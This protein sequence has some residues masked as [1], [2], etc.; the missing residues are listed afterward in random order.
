M[1]I[2]DTA[3][4]GGRRRRIAAVM[5][6][7]LAAV[8]ALTF[9]AL[10]SSDDAEAHGATVFPGSRQYLCYFDAV[11]ANG[12]LDPYNESCQNALDQGGPNAF[13]NWFGNLDSNGA[14][15]TVGYIP[16]G[17]IC[18]GGGRGPYDFEAFNDPGNW[19]RTHVTAGDTVEWR[20]NNWA[21]HPGKFDLYI[22]KD[23]WD[24]NQPIAWD[25]LE[26]FKTFTNPA[27]NGGPGSN[28]HYYYGN[29]TL[30]Q[31][32][33]YHVV[34]T[35]WVRSDSNENFYACSDVEFDGGNG[36]VS[37]IRPGAD[38]PGNDGGVVDP[39]TDPTSDDPTDDPTDEPTTGGP[40][41]GD[42]TATASVN[43]WGSGATV[44]ITV[45]NTGSDPVSDWMIHW[46]WPPDSGITIANSW[47][48]TISSMGDMQMAGPA[49]WNATIASGQ[50]VSFGFNVNGSLSTMPALDCIPG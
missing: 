27:S 21:H 32:S 45:S 48:T 29:L 47:N 30:P 14:G 44:T 37:G 12:A 25:D 6:L 2:T 50:D 31:K 10:F 11:S 43:S 35:H 22:T 39:P 28:D 3:A 41:E 42:C 36:E 13:Y 19:P 20:Y 9:T 16:D 26:L 46:L 33:G 7:V 49:G 8:T 15:Q 34:F 4:L 5:S 18:D 17:R 40:T 23:G 38:L 1:S 24:P